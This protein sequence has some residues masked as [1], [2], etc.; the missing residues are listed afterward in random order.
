LIYPF[1]V[2][3]QVLRNRGSARHRAVMAVFQV[4]ARFPEALGQFRFLCDR[5]FGR[6]SRLIEYK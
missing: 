2:L 5:L 4:L 3:R 6:S 1:Q